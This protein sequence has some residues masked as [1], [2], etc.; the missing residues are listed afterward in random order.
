MLIANKFTVNEAL[1]ASAAWARIAFGGLIPGS[2]VILMSI[3]VL[4]DEFT[5]T[6]KAAIEDRQARVV[7]LEAA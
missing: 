1:G 2:S 7:A 5:A 3:G 6:T 4:L